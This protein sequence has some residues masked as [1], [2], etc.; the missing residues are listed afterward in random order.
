MA[1]KKTAIRS[2]TYRKTNKIN[3]P[4]I[5][6]F[7]NA[8][9]TSSSYTYRSI[10]KKYLEFTQKSAKELLEIKSNDKNYSV[11]ASMMDF[12]KWLLNNEKSEKYCAT[13]IGCVRGFYSY[14]RMP[15]VFRKQESKKLLEA[16]RKT[17]DYL[18]DREDLAKM[19]LAGSL[20]ER[21]ILLAGKSMGLR[22]SD[23]VSIRYGQFRALKLD[24]EPP[25]CV[26][27]IATTKEKVPAY[28]FLDTDAVPI[29]KAWLDAHKEAKDSDRILDDKEDN[30]SIALQTLAKKAGMEIENGQIHGKRVRFHCMRKFLIDRLSAHAS[31]SQWKQIVGKAIDEGAYVSHDQL[32]GVYSRA[33]KDIVINGNGIKS[34]KL[35]ELENAM[36]QLERE[37]AASKTRIDGLQKQTTE[38]DDQLKNINSVI[39]F[40]RIEDTIR[41]VSAKCPT[42][43]EM[44][45]YLKKRQVDPAI[46][47]RPELYCLTY[48]QEA[49]RWHYLPD[50][51]T[52]KIGN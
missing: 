5:E 16:N 8:Q 26:G 51:D 11:E 48:S 37:N 24:N 22:A 43:E 27:E 33:M 1:I 41:F 39:D 38:L 15:L 28:P 36:N 3:D 40:I 49:K 29:V 31:E 12:R 25:I 30:L 52:Y 23:F 45:D 18:F 47:R 50:M 20:K 4:V 10:L 13:S 14:Y 19:A 2:K 44:L 34:K 21:Y 42:Q 32:R 6:E 7:L 35:V 46:L 9:K 17:F